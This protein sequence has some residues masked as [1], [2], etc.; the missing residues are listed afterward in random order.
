TRDLIVNT[1]SGLPDSN[2][3]LRKAFY[4]SLSQ[5]QCDLAP[6]AHLALRSRASTPIRMH[7]LE[8]PGPIETSTATPALCVCWAGLGSVGQ[9]L[10]SDT[11][12]WPRRWDRKGAW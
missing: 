5:A 2:P 3:D 10:S 9:E 8:R 7:R 12:T 11:S 4:H 1:S 6:T